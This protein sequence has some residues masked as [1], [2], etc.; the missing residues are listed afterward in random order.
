MYHYLKIKK[1]I[2]IYIFEGHEIK[3]P[4]DLIGL[5]IV[6]QSLSFVEPI[7]QENSNKDL[8]SRAVLTLPNNED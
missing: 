7:F 3:S 2:Y 4:I 1:Y 8:N 6:F 5:L